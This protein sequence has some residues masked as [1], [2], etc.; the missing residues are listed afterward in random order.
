MSYIL[1]EAQ[2]DVVEDVLEK[3][4]MD[5]NLH[6][7]ILID[8]AGNIIAGYNGKDINHDLYSLA[9]LAAGN[10]GAVCTMAELIGEDDFS[11]LFN[12]GKK[13]NLHFSKVTDEFLLITIFGHETSLGLLRLKLSEVTRKIEDVLA[14]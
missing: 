12:K 9:A 6:S 13:G 2:L 1:Q 8:L 5:L 10:F 3:D 4:L 11:L 7:V 14:N